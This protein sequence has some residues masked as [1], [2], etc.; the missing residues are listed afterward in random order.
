MILSSH[1]PNYWPYPGLLGKIYMSDTFIYCT[2]I[3]FEIKSWQKRN[4]IRTKDSWVYINVP[5]IKDKQEQLICDVQIDND[6]D[7]RSK[8]YKTILN[9]YGKSAY[10]KDYKDFIEDLYSREWTNLTDLDIYIMNWLL[11]ELKIPTKILYDRDFNF[12]GKKTDLLI[13]M[14]EKTGFDT[15]LSNYGSSAYVQ[16]PR[17]TERGLNHKY[18][19]Y[20]GCEYK[21]VYPGFEPGLSVLDMLCNCG[22]EETRRI[23]TDKNNY[24]L[25]ELNRDLYDE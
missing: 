12:E 10:F 20:K 25:S 9:L 7:W 8:T 13:S 18:I 16:I 21:Q 11:D 3:Q 14:C 4:R 17:F 6:Q 2:K 24:C 15:Y 23:I 22:T 5:V 1:Q 19:D